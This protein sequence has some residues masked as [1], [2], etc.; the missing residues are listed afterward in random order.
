MLESEE[1]LK[2]AKASIAVNAEEVASKRQNLDVLV[3]A[4][5][6]EKTALEMRLG[7]VSGIDARLRQVEA[8]EARIKIIADQIAAERTACSELQAEV[9]R[10]REAL[11]SEQVA[12]STSRSAAAAAEAACANLVAELNEKSRLVCEREMTCDASEARLKSQS[13]M[14]EERLKNAEARLAHIEETERLLTTR[15]ADMNAKLAASKRHVEEQLKATEARGKALADREKVLSEFFVFDDASSSPDMQSPQRRSRW[16]RD[17]IVQRT[18]TTFPEPQI[19]RLPEDLF[20]SDWGCDVL[21]VAKVVRSPLQSFAVVAAKRWE[22]IDIIVPRDK[23]ELFVAAVEAGYPENP[24][25]NKFHA[26]DVLQSV[27]SF[28]SSCSALRKSMTAVEKFAVLFAAVVHDFKHPGRGNSFLVNT[29]DACA[30]RYNC[31]SPLENMHVSS[32]FELMCH[33]KLDV[34]VLMDNATALEFHQLVCRLV[35]GTDMARHRTNV[36]AWSRR[37][38]K[39]KGFNFSVAEERR[40][41]LAMLLHAA[42][43]GAQAKSPQV[44]AKW[45]TILEEFR[46]Q[47]EDERKHGLPV[48][49]GCEAGADP[50]LAGLKFLDAC[51]IPLFQVVAQVVPEVPQ[52]LLYLKQRRAA[53]AKQVGADHTAFPAKIVLERNEVDEAYEQ[54]EKEKQRLLEA[55][56]RVAEREQ[57]L[58][59]AAADV[60]LKLRDADAARERVAQADN[61]LQQKVTALQQREQEAKHLDLQL[62]ALRAK[63]E[64]IRKL[65]QSVVDVQVRAVM[66]ESGADAVSQEKES[67]RQ[68]ANVLAAREERIRSMESDAKHKLALLDDREG[69]MTNLGDQLKSLADSIKQ[70]K[71]RAEALLARE[72]E[73]RLKEKATSMI[74]NNARHLVARS[75]AVEEMEQRLQIHQEEINTTLAQLKLTNVKAHHQHLSVLR[76]HNEMQVILDR[77]AA[78][79]E[80]IAQSRFRRQ[81]AAQ[82]RVLLQ[83]DGT[84]L[85]RLEQSIYQFTHQIAALAK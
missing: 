12:F 85:A 56:A 35:L 59:K 11:R 83:N 1:S 65:L 60:E 62:D 61:E 34:T 27:F 21:E 15:E 84:P 13:E 55:E 51:A 43:I 71:E 42:D 36:Q 45:G 64:E 32:A 63:E 79:G 16:L 46:S 14:L 41:V 73:I 69:R 24:Y 5:N 39:G 19:D 2:I 80:A 23:W 22:L 68:A 72:E 82:A 7:E 6:Q 17:S 3:A 28:V 77:E 52:T 20:L 10:D 25:H 53:L 18:K 54:A 57:A 9:E 66:V 8:E 29:L 70:D 37:V 48:T 31:Q 4:L 38:V 30:V 67:L 44:A 33:Q 81:R 76:C 26:A 49:P 78:V 75:V 40:E 50:V 58:E 74:A 47:G